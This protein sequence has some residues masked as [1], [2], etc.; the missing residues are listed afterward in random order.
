MIYNFH[1][2]VFGYGHLLFEEDQEVDGCYL[3][4]KGSVLLKK[5]QSWGLNGKKPT[6]FEI[7]LEQQ[8]KKKEKKIKEDLE[9]R[10]FQL[11]FDN[12]YKVSST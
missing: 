6:N 9:V 8:A 3:I 12:Q 1:K 7:F 2:K 11:R 4:K 5:S 10:N